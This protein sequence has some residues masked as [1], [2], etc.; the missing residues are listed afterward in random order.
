MFNNSTFSNNYDADVPSN[1]LQIICVIPEYINLFFLSCS[2]YGMYQGI[3]I[4]H[5]LYAVLFLNL[6]VSLISSTV[7]IFVFCFISTTSYVLFS[8]I[9][10]GLSL[11]FHC[12]S[13]CVTSILRFV[14][15]IHGDW[16][17]NWIPSQKFQCA[18]ALIMT[19]LLTV[20]QSLPT[21]AVLMSYGKQTFFVGFYLISLGD[22][23]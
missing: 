5:P 18:S 21:F 15:I 2:I 16:F 23:I 3:E 9:M 13:W 7:D 12:T 19:C 1:I 8:N 6:I 14:Y 22:K 4:A 11:F 10:N 17:N 20:I